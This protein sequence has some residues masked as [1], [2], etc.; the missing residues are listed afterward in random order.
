MRL[1]LA[2][3]D[4]IWEEPLSNMDKCQY[5]INLATNNKV[6][7]ILFPEMVLTGFTMNI[8]KL[9]LSEKDI[10]NWFKDKAI[11]NKINIGFGY[12]IR[13]GAK[14]NNKFAIISKEGILLTNYS[15]IHPFSY[16]GED[17]KYYR[18]EEICFCNIESKIITP[19]ICYDLRFPEIFQIA[20]KTSKFIAVAAN[21]PKSRQ[22]HWLTL[23]KARAIENQCFIAGVNRIGIGDKIEYGGAS[24]IINPQGEVLNEISSKEE[25]IITEIDFN[26]VDEI[27]DSFSLKK[28]RR[29][30]LY[31]KEYEKSFIN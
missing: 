31:K 26:L 12:A 1:G 25:L 4:V 28:D 18:G 14:G 22:D 13:V 10:I 20:S 23:L 30:N 3:M 7:L 2:Q 6:E 9:I 27:R 15:K 5:F 11:E 8:E 19:F 17:E 21:W 24:V 29:E 16:G